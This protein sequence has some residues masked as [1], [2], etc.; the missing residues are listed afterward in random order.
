M[1]HYPL[2]YC[3]LLSELTHAGKLLYL[4]DCRNFCLIYPL[5]PFHLGSTYSHPELIEMGLLINL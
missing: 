1:L 4:V 5:L 2:C 3:N